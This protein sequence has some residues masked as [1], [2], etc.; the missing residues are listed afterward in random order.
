MSLKCR[1]P[2]LN[3]LTEKYFSEPPKTDDGLVDGLTNPGQSAGATIRGYHWMA[4]MAYDR[5]YTAVMCRVPKA[6]RVT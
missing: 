4:D 1:V 3:E 2:F 6:C 5:V